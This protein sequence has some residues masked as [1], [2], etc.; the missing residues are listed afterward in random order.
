[1]MRD[2]EIIELQGKNDKTPTEIERFAQLM[3]IETEH[4]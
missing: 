1:M 4:S 3:W 2:E